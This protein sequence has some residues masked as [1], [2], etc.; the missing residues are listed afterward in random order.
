MN[1]WDIVILLVV[2]VAAGLAIRRV[3]SRKTGC[4]CG[5]GGCGGAERCLHAARKEEDQSNP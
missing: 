5:C 4:N 3:L 1:I 2:A